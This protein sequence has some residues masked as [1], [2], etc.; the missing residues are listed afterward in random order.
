[1]AKSEGKNVGKMERWAS[2]VGG[3]A[4]VAFALRR[5]RRLS[6]LSGA[7]ALG[8]AAL[9]L[10]G[11]TGHCAAYGALG[12]NTAEPGDDWARPL[13][14]PHGKDTFRGKWKLPEGARTAGSGGR[15]VV[16]EDS[17]ASFPASD[18]PSF[19]PTRV[20]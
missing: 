4:L 8:A 1:M 19:T 5:E 3:G 17:A 20:G 6:P 9:L 10:R 16:E 15:D 7:L 18:P 14:R 2:V 13:S 12:L 11:A